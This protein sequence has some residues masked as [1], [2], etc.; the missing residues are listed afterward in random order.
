MP[1]IECDVEEARRTLADAGII[2]SDAKF[3]YEQWRAKHGDAVAIAYDDKLVIQGANPQDIEAILRDAGGHAYLY[4]D[5]ASRGNPGPAATGWTIVTSDGI[6]AEGG[7]KIGRA[8]NNQAEYEALI[9]AL[10][11]ARDYGFD[12][13]DVK[14]DSQLIVKQVTGAWKTNNPELRER[15][16]RA[17]ELLDGFD[18]WSLKHVP[19]EVNERADKLAN[20]ALDDG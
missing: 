7:T 1:V 6:T 13:V 14:G 20:E 11:A 9:E 4:F 19:R 2:V 17:R 3:E 18:K 15:R 10:E 12:S 16:V 8:T 5:G